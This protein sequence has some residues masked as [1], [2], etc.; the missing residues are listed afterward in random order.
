MAALAGNIDGAGGVAGTAAVEMRGE[1]RV[2]LQAGEESLV[3]GDF[4]VHQ[5]DGVVGV[6]R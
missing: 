1:Q 6:G 2:T 3:A 5:D 4:D